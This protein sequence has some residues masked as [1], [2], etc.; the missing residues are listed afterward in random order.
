[1][2]IQEILEHLLSPSTLV[3]LIPITAIVGGIYASI[4]KAELK[5]KERAGL[6]SEEK[7]MFKQLL[8]RNQEIDK[9]LENLESI[10]TSLD[11]D[12]LALK[13]SDDSQENKKKV[14]QIS[15]NLKSK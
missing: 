10:I 4:K 7:E 6:S 9:R 3:F 13:P 2:D 14:E 12:L 1:M 15:Q 11:K 5:A 8:Y